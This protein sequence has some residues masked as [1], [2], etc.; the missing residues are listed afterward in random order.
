MRLTNAVL[1]R[2]V[3]LSGHSTDVLSPQRKN[4]LGGEAGGVVL[5]AA[6]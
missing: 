2:K 5:T 1:S 3:D 4:L 6:S